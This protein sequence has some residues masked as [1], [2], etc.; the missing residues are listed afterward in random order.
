MSKRTNDTVVERLYVLDGG[1]IELDKSSMTFGHDPGQKVRVPTP[2]YLIKTRD[3]FVLFDTGW[4][5][6]AIPILESMGLK[7]A[8]DQSRVLPGVLQSLGLDVRDIS[9]IILSHLHAD[10]AGGIQYFPDAE[11]IVQKDEYS[12]ALHPHSF[13][14]LAYLRSAIDFPSFKWRLIDGDQEIMPGLTVVLAN[15]H[16]PGLQALIVELPEAGTIILASDSCYVKRNIE[17][18]VIPGIVWNPTLALHSIT[19]LKTLAK[20]LNGTVYPNHDIEFWDSLRKSP[21][22]Y[23]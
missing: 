8:I 18:E 20:L 19:K 17:E 2:I 4:Y 13:S 15:G 1:S 16:T 11:L 7:P 9:K 14:Q 23:R 21:D 3:D 5:P 6:Q 12:Y 10:H 22:H